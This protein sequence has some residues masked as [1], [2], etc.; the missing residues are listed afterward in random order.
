MQPIRLRL[1]RALGATALAV[2]L[3]T[4]ALAPARAA[5]IEGQHYDD[6][7]TLSRSPL[8]LNGVG[9][10]GVA[11][12]RAFVVGL[13]VE[14]PSSEP[15]SLIEATGPKRLAIRML[16]D[17]PIEVFA[18]AITHGM[19]KN[20]TPEEQVAMAD[21]VARFRA[22]VV[23]VG[24]VHVGDRIDL[25]YLPKRGL[26][27]SFNGHE[28]GAAVQGEDL[29]RA[30]LKIFIGERAVDKKLRQ[31]LLAGGVNRPSE[32]V[33]PVAMAPAEPSASAPAVSP[34]ASE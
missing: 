23:A 8:Q 24:E 33:A 17:A 27:F 19:N 22:N 34:A 13:Y 30:L 28:R 21:R 10:R 20:T 1:T 9:L 3:G 6:A 32:P 7:I 4:Q 2:L 5:S 15:A 12:I 11:F 18:N 31:A 14:H 29:Y 16:M 26:V 25:D